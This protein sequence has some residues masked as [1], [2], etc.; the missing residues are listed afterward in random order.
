MFSRPGQRKPARSGRG[1][2]DI[3]Y[4]RRLLPLRLSRA[5]RPLDA[6]ARQKKRKKKI[7]TPFLQASVAYSLRRNLSRALTYSVH[8]EKSAILGEACAESDSGP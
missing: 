7:I 3:R 4:I 5:P 2:R 8:T 6:L 1:E